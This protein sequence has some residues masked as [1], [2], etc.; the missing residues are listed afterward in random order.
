MPG[1]LR[2]QERA[3]SGAHRR[4]ERA[5]VPKASKLPV[6]VSRA[7]RL[8]GGQRQQEPLAPEPHARRHAKR[9]HAGAAG[10]QH[11]QAHLGRVARVRRRTRHTARAYP[12]ER[13]RI[14]AAQA[15]RADTRHTAPRAQD[16]DRRAEQGGQEFLADGTGDSHRRGR[17]MAG[18]SL[19]AGQSAVRQSGNR[20]GVVHRPVYQDIRPAGRC[21][22][23]QREH[24][25]VEPTRARA[26]A[27]QA[28]SHTG[29]AHEGRAVCRRHNRP[30]IQGHN[31]RREQRQRH[32]RVLQPVR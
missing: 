31:R 22:A 30:D 26:A 24:N 23:A 5:G 29:Q 12:P 15:A 25:G 14:A 11:R 8:P 21:A 16:A 18:L 27:G 1:R 19:R 2:R 32:G 10:H 7:A 20:P 9:R 28:G 17:H 3:R 4:A 6:P 13:H